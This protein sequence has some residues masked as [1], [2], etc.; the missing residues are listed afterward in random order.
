[1]SSLPTLRRISLRS[2]SA[3]RLRLF[4]TALAVVLGTS[5]VAGAFLLTA[6]LSKAFDDIT[7]GNY[8]GVDVVLNSSPEVPLTFRMSEEIAGRADVEITDTVDQTPVII[9]DADGDPLQTGGAGS[10]LLP[11]TPPE[12]AVSPVPSIIDGVA[13]AGPGGAVLNE[14]AA[15]AAGLTVGDT[16]TVIDATGR[17]EFVLDGL[18]RFETATG[19][20]AGLQIPD[21][22][23]REGFTDGSH[24][25]RIVV[26]AAGA[27]ADTLKR[28]LQASL[29]G[30]DIATGEEAAAQESE[31]VRAQ[32]AF[33]TYLLLVFGL[34]GLLVGTFIISNTF[35]MIVAQRTREFA[36]LRAMGMSRGQLSGSIL[37]EAVIIA[38]FG[39][40]LGI[41]VGVGLVELIT[42]AMDAAG[43]GLPDAGLGIDA[44]SVLVPLG[45]GIV[46]TVLS[47]W[48]PA[49]RA[50]RVH[51]VQAMRSGD[52]ST[53][54]PLRARTIIGVVLLVAGLAATLT[55]ALATGWSTGD[56]GVLTGAGTVGV[57]LGVLLIGAV[58]SRQLF[59]ARF[60]FGGAVPLLARTNLSRNPR[61]TAATAFALTLG[62]ALVTAVGILGASMQASIF[63]QIDESLRADAVVSAGFV[64]AQGVP[65]QAAEDLREVEGVADVMP[66]TWAPVEIDGQATTP[67]GPGVNPVLVTDPRVAVE[68]EIVAGGFD[69]VAETSGVGLDRSTAER[70]GLGV[71][72]IVTVTAPGLTVRGAEVPVLVV[73]ED[74]SAY[75][76][77]AVSE[78]TA[79]ELVPDR[80]TWFTQNVF[81]TFDEDVD[82]EAVLAAVTEE[83]NAYGVLQVMDRRQYRDSSAGQIDQLMSIIYALLALSVVIAVLGIVNTLALS[84]TERTREFGML[85]AVGTQRSQVR[86]MI[87]LES[88]QIAMLGAVAGVIV[89]V[90]LGWCLVRILADQGIDRW[91]IPWDQIAW[92][93]LGAVVVGA[94]AAVWPARRAA[95]TRPLAAVD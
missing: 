34:I 32:L 45:V 72:D 80:S 9:L 58:I 52:Q 71:G 51:P 76:P 29:P 89:G 4:L 36:L 14:A 79:V 44:T 83:M 22:R 42:W 69:D 57:V 87:A 8:D 21:D 56:R 81:V 48:V 39:S 91:L 82:E 35:S 46:V 59:S 77:A 41:L 92:L 61:R 33:L 55:A 12:E 78:V 65:D 17:H 24:T 70:S 23:Y 18:T 84:I 49:R 26:R 53:A 62:V 37:V 93:L 1:M 16:L 50:G 95:G 30:V 13:P 43:F 86:W 74:N 20:W 68:L 7:E 40:L 6:T 11:W 3:H 19:G 63:G 90:W 10:W 75:A 60:R 27:D 25:D 73:W 38:V 88:V 67:V 66:A 94:V 54:V 31:E 2:L 5:F 47:A 28:G 85:R 15:E 64:T